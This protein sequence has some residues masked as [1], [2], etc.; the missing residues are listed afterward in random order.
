[1]RRGCLEHLWTSPNWYLLLRI[2][3]VRGTV[4]AGTAAETQI[5]SAP[6]IGPLA[7]WQVCGIV[8]CQ[9][10]VSGYLSRPTD[11]YMSQ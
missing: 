6:R 11:R 3:H 1:L 2:H 10:L 4:S 9:P 5:E 8:T 7:H